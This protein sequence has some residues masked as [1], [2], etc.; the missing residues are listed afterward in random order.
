VSDWWDGDLLTLNF[1]CNCKIGKNESSMSATCTS[2]DDD[3][4]DDDENRG[5]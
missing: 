2:I 3:D 1:V 4:D 5:K